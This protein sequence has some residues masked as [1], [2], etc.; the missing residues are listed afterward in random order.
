MHFFNNDPIFMS[1]ALQ[2]AKRGR[3]TTRANPNVGCVLVKDAQLIAEGWHYRAGEAHAEVHALQQLSSG[4]VGAQGA[5]A[6][7][8]LEPC[9]HQGKTGSCASALIDAGVARV[10]YAMEDP[11]PLVSGKGLA[12]LRAA[13]IIVVGPLLEMQAIE[14]NQGFISRMQRQRPWLRCKIAT[15]LDGRSAMASGESQWITG[16]AARQDV[17][18]LRAQSCAII[19]GIG[20]IEHDNSR[21]SVRADECL[22][23]NVD[24]VLALPPLRVVLDSQLRIDK[25]ARIFTAVG[26]VII[27]TGSNAGLEKEAQ[28]RSQWPDNVI[29]ERVALS[30]GKVGLAQVLTCLAERYECNDVL[31]EAGATLSGAFMQADLIDELIIYQ[32]PILLGSDARGL[33]D[34]P[35]QSM[36]EKIQLNI[37]DQRSIGDDLRITA[38]VCAHKIKPQ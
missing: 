4:A 35:L 18:L 19:T 33:M 11:N 31:V 2:L 34:L 7:V 24:D 21:L 30:A 9:A 1:R 6:Y 38:K 10:V 37:I 36:Q 22:I 20:S 32:A 13:G 26:R 3:Y 27:F 14:L 5:T 16:A 25:D 28:L 15:S 8:T 29:V 23:D 17:Q 12:L